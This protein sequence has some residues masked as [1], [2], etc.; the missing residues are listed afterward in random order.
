MSCIHWI[1]P[2]ESPK[3][4]VN[5]YSKLV[6]KKIDNMK[7]ESPTNNILAEMVYKK[8]VPKVENNL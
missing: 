3:I 5:E 7:K 4:L 1:F 6:L 8:L 2:N